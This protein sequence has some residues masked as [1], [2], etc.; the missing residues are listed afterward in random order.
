MNPLNINALRARPRG[1]PD[2][3]SELQRL[4][5]RDRWLIELLA[6][7]HVFTT[8]QITTLAF[9]HVHTARNRLVLLNKRGF[10]ARFRNAQRPGSEQWRWT[11][12]LYAYTWLADRDGAPEPKFPTIRKTI[13]RLASSAKLPHLLAVNDLFTDL[14]GYAREREY[15][16]LSAW[17]SEQQCTQVTG[18]LLRP[19]GHGTWTEAGQTLPFWFE[20]DNGTYPMHQV[21]S[22]LDNY[23]ILHRETRRD[24][25]VLL[26]F[27]TPG[28]EESFHTKANS[29]PA[30]SGGLLIATASGQAHPAGPVWR[31]LGTTA[32]YR[33]AALAALNLQQ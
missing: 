15:A 28:R 33:L 21:V 26:R 16:G 17:W 14:A 9:D 3:A 1:G 20:Q 11:L 18:T 31:P 30:A 10:L 25:A 4:M 23:L 32:R 19:D 29:H 6:Q 8:S 22:K 24:E 7:H 5:P 12:D 2:I 13:N 27:S